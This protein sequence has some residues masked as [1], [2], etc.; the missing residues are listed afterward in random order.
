MIAGPTLTANASHCEYCNDGLPVEVTVKTTEVG[1][2]GVVVLRLDDYRKRVLDSSWWALATVTVVDSRGVQVAGALEIHPGFS[3][4]GWR[5]T[6]VWTPGLY[7]VAIEVDLMGMGSDCPSVSATHE[8]IVSNDVVHTVGQR[9][10]VVT[11]SYDADPRRAIDTM[12]CCD[13][14]LPWE[15]PASGILCP[16][17]PEEQLNDHDACA[18]LVGVGRLL[19]GAELAI[20]GAP[21][22]NDYTIREVTKGRTSAA[23][24]PEMS[25]SLSAPACLEF[26]V[27]DLVTGETSSHASCH[28]GAQSDELGQIEIDPTEALAAQCEGPAYVCEVVGATGYARWD[29]EACTLW[30]N[31]EPFEHPDAAPDELGGTSTG[32][33]AAAVDDDGCGCRT[34]GSSAWWFVWALVPFARRGRWDPN[35]P[36]STEH[37]KQDTEP[38][39]H[40]H[41]R[42][43]PDRKT[44]SDTSAPHG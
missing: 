38:P 30:P 5:P 29:P 2:D 20:D 6:A 35:H 34:S 41:K 11:E 17:Y 40:P 31:G 24:D 15:A 33:D 21:A 44:A 39:S 37:Q 16:G 8:V 7:E 23:G 22:P 26:E 1:I 43:R 9:S 27:L 10:V 13:G 42:R 25:S 18:D 19:I 12:V 32:A 28:G 3:V 36:E 4:A 14:L